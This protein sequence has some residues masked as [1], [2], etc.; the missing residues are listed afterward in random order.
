VTLVLTSLA[1]L[2]AAAALSLLFGR[3]PRL[4]LGVALAGVAVSAVLMVVASVAA[5]GQQTHLTDLSTSWPMPLGTARLAIDGLSAWFLIGIGV[6]SLSVAFYS[7]GY[8]QREMA[9]GGVPVFGALLCLLVASLVAVVCAADIV[10]FLVGWESMTLCAF[11][12]V[13]F[14]DRDPE[15]RRGAW[16]YIVATHL[17][18]ALCVLPMFAIIAGRAGTTDFAAFPSAWGAVGSRD[19][20]LVFLLGLIGF[21]TKAG[22]MPMHVWLPVAHPIA[23]TPVSAL[24]SGVVIKTG[25]YGL[26]RLLTWLP[27]LPPACAVVVLMVAMVSGV[28]GVLY[29][30]AQ[31]DLKRLLAYHSVENIGIIGVGIGVGMLGQSSGHATV[32]LL[33]YAGAL[34]H[35]LNHALFKALLFFSA[36][37]V[38]FSTH[39]GQMDRLGGLAKRTPINAFLFLVGAVAICGLP[40]LNGFV[41]EWL[42]YGSLFYRAVGTAGAFAAAPVVALVALAL[43]GALALACFAKVYAVVFLGEP[44]DPLL[45]VRPIPKTMTAGMALLA[46]PCVTIGVFPAYFV[47][48]VGPAV[49][50]LVPQL[51]DEAGSRVDSML[52]LSGRLGWLAAALAAFLVV[53]ALVRRL[54]ERSTSLRSFSRTWGCGYAFPTPRMQF[55]ASSFAWSLIGS[56]RSLLWPE[57]HYAPPR[58]PF[59]AGGR[60]VTHTAD[61]VEH[62]VLAPLFRGAARVGA[63]G[64]TLTWTGRAAVGRENGLD[65]V[66]VTS[67]PLGRIAHRVVR[68]LRRG[69]IHVYLGFIVLTLIGVFVIE[70]ASSAGA[71]SA[72]GPLPVHQSSPAG[73]NR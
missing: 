49:Q 46:V 7:W 4:A 39:C 13:G 31:H 23:P 56:F 65:R 25:I 54:F 73:E 24:L 21:G 51:A 71:A 41:S 62:D 14:H 16:M 55:T 58:G 40:P 33:G 69:S 70:A 1:L 17:G 47:K 19:C 59:P 37:G 2:L 48:L 18:T 5:I 44:R 36:G 10:L 30:L 53:L 3:L 67:R 42:V 8:M 12:L 29:A 34:L 35:V 28:L 26:L 66:A 43:M 38:I 6:L 57:R 15:A 11:F 27:P 32:A 45:S 68:A 50:R 63:M 61:L 64:R 60:L 9:H 72:V 22:F 52:A 20:A